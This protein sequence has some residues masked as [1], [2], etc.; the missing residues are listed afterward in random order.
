MNFYY[1]MEMVIL[2]LFV[3]KL[4]LSRYGDSFSVSLSEIC[5]D[6]LGALYLSNFFYLCI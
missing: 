5:F 3:K 1:F 2:I 6:N 4:L